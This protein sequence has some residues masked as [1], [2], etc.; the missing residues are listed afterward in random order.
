MAEV[1]NYTGM[2]NATAVK[3]QVRIDVMEPIIQALREKFGED[4]VAKVGTN[5]Y[6][7]VVGVINDKDGFPQDICATIK[8][9]VKEWESRKTAKKTYEKYDIIAESEA[10]EM[11]VAEKEEEKARKAK[12]KE[13]KIAKDKAMREEKKKKNKEEE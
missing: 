7:V 3:A 2:K 4:S 9:T 11:E 5:E 1:K 12:A 10:Y 8:P 6:A 13:G